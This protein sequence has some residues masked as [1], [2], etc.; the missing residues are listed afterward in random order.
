MNCSQNVSCHLFSLIQFGSSIDT[1]QVIAILYTRHQLLLKLTSTIDLNGLKRFAKWWSN[2]LILFFTRFFTFDCL[3]SMFV[4]TVRWWRFW[5]GLALFPNGAFGV[6]SDPCINLRNAYNYIVLKKKWKKNQI[7]LKLTVKVFKN[8]WINIH[9]STHLLFCY[10][11]RFIQYN[12]NCTFPAS[13]MCR[14]S[15]ICHVRISVWN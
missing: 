1:K 10:I 8:N 2:Y 12:P 7:N 11:N 4:R 3:K 13:R 14:R 15:F 9:Q 6:C 5:T